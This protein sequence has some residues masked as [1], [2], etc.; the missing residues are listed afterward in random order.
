MKK[1]FLFLVLLLLPVLVYAENCDTSNITVTS[2]KKINSSGYTEEIEEPNTDNT[3]V[4]TNLRLYD[5]GDSITYEVKIKNKTN[6]DY[7]LNKKINNS[8]YVS[9][10]IISDDN[11][12]KANEE[13][14]INLRIEYKNK[15]PDNLY[16]S[17]KLIENKQIELIVEDYII[18]PSTG[19]NIIITLVIFLIIFLSLLS[20]KKDLKYRSLLL[21]F[22]IPLIV[23]ASCEYKL[24]IN[25]KAEFKKILPN[26]CTYE[27]EL[28]QGAEYTNGQYTYKYMNGYGWDSSIGSYGGY[29]WINI[30]EDGWGVKLTNPDSTDPVTT[31]LCSSI[32]DK[33]IVSMGGMFYLSHATTIDLSSFDTS[34]VID[35]IN[36]FGGSQSTTLDLSSFDTSKVTNMMGMFSGSQVTNLDLSSFDT[37][38]VI[39]MAYMFYQSQATTL[40]LSNFDTRNVSIMESMFGDSQAINLDLSSFNT[41]NVTNM[42]GMF[43]GSQATTLDLSSFD[44]KN[45]TY[46]SYMFS[47][48]QATIL[49]LSSF[50]M[51]KVTDVSNKYRTFYNAV[52]TIGYGRTQADCDILN[53]SEQKPPYLT[54]VVKES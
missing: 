14:T 48:S 17:N 13:K 2:I 51:S 42:N 28:V 11:K 47:E 44:T 21:L 49:D 37:S 43:G 41:S 19:R 39:D 20:I 31:K 46:I 29:G 7:D 35:M 9:Y 8:E 6:K 40:D 32:N 12:I 22:F 18:N 38:N 30:T 25:S 23:E 10:E 54:F 36:M 53:S 50:D 3:S 26:P 33:P 52:A 1:R 34:N 24:S 16:K 15:V 4:S 45:V 27:G 5:V